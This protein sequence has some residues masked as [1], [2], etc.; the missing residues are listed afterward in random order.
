[1]SKAVQMN[2]SCPVILR[3]LVLSSLDDSQK[4]RLQKKKLLVRLCADHNEEHVLHFQE[5]L[6]LLTHWSLK[7]ATN[8]VQLKLNINKNNKKNS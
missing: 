6:R 3:K 2:H 8:L 5:W 4:L 7:P 1:M